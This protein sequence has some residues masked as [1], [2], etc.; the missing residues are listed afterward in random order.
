MR[1]DRRA[2]RF[3]GETIVSTIDLPLLE[4]GDAFDPACTIEREPPGDR[5]AISHNWFHHWRIGRQAPWLSF[6]RTDDGYLLRFRDLADFLVS[7]DGAQIRACPSRAPDDTLRHL[8]LD[9]VL[10]LA[11][12]RRGRLLLHASAVRIAGIG[13]LA[14]AGPTGR[15]KS[16][17][18]AAV[19]SRGGRILSDDCLA[20]ESRA[21]GLN[22]LPAYPGLRL[23]PDGPSRALRRGTT[24]GP[25]AHYTR[26]RRVNGGALRFHR[27]PSPLRA[28]FLL[29]E[30]GASDPTVRIRRCR[31][32]ARL[33]G[34]VKYAYLLDIEDREQL[35]RTF[36]RLA[37][38]ATS[39]PILRL[40]LRHGH[41]RLAGAAEEICTYAKSLPPEGGSHPPSPLRGFGAAGTC[42]S[43]VVAPRP[44]DLGPRPS[45]LGPRTP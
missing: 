15:G 2:Y 38:I 10:P 12:S 45:D 37:S 9:Q 28:L 22:V 26:K 30:R 14:F 23:W 1:A 11:L 35:E 3:C 43:A 27:Q 31:A 8:L 34:L 20:L 16:T 4:P 32:S 19:A 18:A 6:A 33:M 17:L 13:A 25:V 40:R 36:D 5:E 44:S 21:G 42:R 24:G 7:R 29:S 39:V 41:S